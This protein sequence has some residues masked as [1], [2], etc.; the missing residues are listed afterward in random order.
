VELMVVVSIT[1][2]LAALGFASLRKHVTAAWGAEAQ[3]MVQNIRAAE[4]RWRSDHMMYLNVSTAG[5]WYPV[6]ST[7]A[8][9]KGKQRA[10][11]YP[12]GDTTHA[13]SA[14]W[15]ALRPTATGAVRFG[16]L[17]NAGVAGATMTALSSGPAVT[18]AVPPDNWY[19][20]Q[21]MGDMDGNGIAS[22][23]RAS[24]MSGEVFAVNPGE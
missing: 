23:Y 24:S 1:G 5:A 10:F 19:V 9:N 3:T 17:V 7:L 8:A 13:D 16:Y 22:S 18:W 20:I 14:S 11:Y 21:A 15:L 12:P 4:E 6:D 2:I